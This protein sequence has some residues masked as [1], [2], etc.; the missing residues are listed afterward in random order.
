MQ[1]IT[2]RTVLTSTAAVALDP[3]AG[4]MPARAAAPATG[5]QAPGFYRTKV[6]DF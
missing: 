4:L 3:L 1:D 2:R 5:K 6:G